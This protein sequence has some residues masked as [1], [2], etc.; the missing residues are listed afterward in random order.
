M[1]H[2]ATD[3][4]KELLKRIEIYDKFPEVAMLELKRRGGLI[5]SSKQLAMNSKKP[6]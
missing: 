1:E 6:T 4:G 5:H 2:G 3:K